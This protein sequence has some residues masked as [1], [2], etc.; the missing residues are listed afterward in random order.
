MAIIAL[1]SRNQFRGRVVRII[2]GPV[3]SEVQLETPAGTISS[4]VTSSSLEELGLREGHE[5]MAVFKATEVLLAKFQPVAADA[6]SA[7]LKRG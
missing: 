6:P 3:V 1:N 2:R 7:G 5:A 4:V